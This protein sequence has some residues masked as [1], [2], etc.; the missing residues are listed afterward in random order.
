MVHSVIVT[1]PI[2]WAAPSGGTTVHPIAA[3]ISAPP[4]YFFV[5]SVVVD[6]DVVTAVLVV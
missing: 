6:V 1:P 5:G 2:I 3:A 4:A